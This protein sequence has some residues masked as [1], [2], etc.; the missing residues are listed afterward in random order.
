MKYIISG[1]ICERE[2]KLG[3]R[4][5]IVRTYDKGRKYDKL[6]KTTLTDNEGHFKMIY[7][8][9]AAA[10][11]FKSPPEIFLRI[12]T[13][14][15]RFL[16]DTKEKMQWGARDEEKIELE[17]P[18]EQLG[19]LSPSRPDGIVEAGIN[20]TKNDLKIEKEGM[21]D[22]PRLPGWDNGGPVGAP[23]LPEKFQ[24]IVLPLGAKILKVEVHPGQPVCPPVEVNPL[25]VRAP[26]KNMGYDAYDANDSEHRFSER[27]SLMQVYP[28][29]LNQT[30]P[31]PEE[32][33]V[34]GSMRRKESVQIL[35]MLVRP[36]QYDPVK[37]NFV[38]YPN[39]RYAIHYDLF[40]VQS[41]NS[42]EKDQTFKQ[43]ELQRLQTFLERDHVFMA[44]DIGI[45]V[46]EVLD[47]TDIPYV[48][49]SDNFT[50]PEKSK[51]GK[52]AP[53]ND[54]PQKQSLKVN[55]AGP[56]EHFERL[57]KWKTSRGMRT[58][59]V[60]IEDIVAGKYGDCT[61]GN[62]ARDLQ[63]V[64]R[65]FVKMANREWGLDYL[66][67]GG[68]HIIVPMR[69]LLG[70]ITC[71]GM[72]PA[73]DFSR[74]SDSGRFVNP[75]PPRG[76]FL[77]A[78]RKK[79]YLCHDFI[80]GTPDSSTALITSNGKKIFFKGTHPKDK[81][82]WY[83]ADET[84][85][86]LLDNET[87][88]LKEVPHSFECPK[89]YPGV[90]N[91]GTMICNLIVEGPLEDIDDDYHWAL[92]NRLI[93]SDLYYASLDLPSSTYSPHDF[94]SNDNEIYGQ[95]RWVYYVRDGEVPID[96]FDP[97][98]PDVWVGR[99]PI[100]SGE[101]ARSFVDKVLT[102]ER[103]QTPV[104]DGEVP[105]LVDPSYLK[106]VVLAVDHA[107]LSIDSQEHQIW[108]DQ[109]WNNRDP[110]ESGKFICQPNNGSLLVHLQSTLVEK[111]KDWPTVSPHVVARFFDADKGFGMDIK[112]PYQGSDASATSP[113][114]WHFVTE[115]L[116]NYVISK[117][118]TGYASLTGSAFH[119]PPK[120]IVW[121][122]GESREGTWPYQ[123]ESMCRHLS[124][125]F[126]EFN[127]YS[128]YYADYMGFENAQPLTVENIRAALD[129]GCHFVILEG[130]G[131]FNGCSMVWW[132]E[133][134]GS[135]SDF[136]NHLKYFIAVAGSSCST[137][138][139]DDQY[140]SLGET[141]VL[142][143][144]GGAIAYIG[145]TRTGFDN[146]N[147]KKLLWSNL[148][149]YGRLGP[150][151]G[152]QCLPGRKL[153]FV[154][155]RILYGDPEMPV[156]TQMPNTYQVVHPEFLESQGY[157]FDVC[158]L[159]KG[160]P[161]PLQRVTLIGGWTNSQQEPLILHSKLTNESGMS[162]FDLGAIPEDL[163]EITVTVVPSKVGNGELNFVPYFAKILVVKFQGGWLRCTKCGA[164]FF[165]HG[166][167]QGMCPN[168][169]AH[170]A[171]I[172]ENYRLIANSPEAADQQGWLC[173]KNCQSLFFAGE[174]I[175]NA[176]VCR[177][178]NPTD[179]SEKPHDGS[180]SRKYAL[181]YGGTQWRWCSKCQMLHLY[182][183]GLFAPNIRR[184][185]DK[186]GKNHNV[187]GTKYYVH[188]G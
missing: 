48:I 76:C 72:Y 99:A 153:W 86:P 36:V 7:D 61:D 164:L 51:D 34:Q 46:K 50:W 53:K 14:P 73:W 124:E 15:F 45:G 18:R 67:L 181:E 184:C 172:G 134:K 127:E 3:V 49:I 78:N 146:L 69:Y 119:V 158:V 25:P 31:Y 147:E 115:L 13:Q 74:C 122:D 180:K 102:Y 156:W 22:V 64:I 27:E 177:D 183:G 187:G 28:I 133:S 129:K 33:V 105:E 85:G 60:T 171:A 82:V 170:T 140:R 151:A 188:I 117:G 26:K 95:Y 135:R 167:T 97:D 54:D 12:F 148:Y 160:S 42:M 138:V 57:A 108:Q 139:P 84:F 77:V 96:G 91:K 1:R 35:K 163:K 132:K 169:G 94:D 23:S 6:L 21:L 186:N 63:E 161:L 37:H 131:N 176:G 149:R 75:P 126:T 182:Q 162:S 136:N 44:K 141:L 5:L 159:H 81:I 107:N 30:K 10:D 123:A 110:P 52:G 101:E 68:S 24:Y 111:L 143:S 166:S 39:L 55:D 29:Y 125:N 20:L 38:F 106:R 17:I 19:P 58:R 2:S 144:D 157:P 32:L 66:L 155:E 79:A 100:E 185:F 8:E 47:F 165:G 145:N 179:G 109:N 40:D 150:A 65:N 104:E 56:V 114:S 87:Q 93:P 71:E 92:P 43:S 62:N 90:T 128:R 173:C 9:V 41:K 112:I 80:L 116:E 83:F 16:M 70:Y 103:L 174:G 168:G 121:F 113:L 118:P 142:D 98:S 175:T 89:D 137:A 130:H 11:L 120:R 154:Y 4:G 59:V 152:D 88:K 178:D